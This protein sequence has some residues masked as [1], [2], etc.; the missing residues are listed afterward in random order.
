[1][2]DLSK[3]EIGEPFPEDYPDSGRRHNGNSAEWSCRA[4]PNAAIATSGNIKQESLTK[5]L[6]KTHPATGKTQW[7]C[8]YGSS[9]LKLQSEMPTSRRLS[10]PDGCPASRR[11]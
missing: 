3:Y 7:R 2:F 10:G 8:F 4:D 11:G 5:I 1:M 9:N 6:P